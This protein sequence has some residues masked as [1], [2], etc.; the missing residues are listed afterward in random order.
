M[1]KL[2]TNTDE[3]EVE[4]G[5]NITAACEDMGVTF[6]CYEGHCGACAITVDEGTENLNE[7]T[8]EEKALGK[9]GKERLACQCKIKGGDVKISF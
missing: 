4:D 1:A 9:E 7:P 6:G 8:D 2:K 5:A 3:A